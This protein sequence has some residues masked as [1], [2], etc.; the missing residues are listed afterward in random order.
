MSF[1]FVWLLAPC[2]IMYFF[3]KRFIS[4]KDY[5]QVGSGVLILVLFS[6][7]LS[8]IY[9]D[10]LVKPYMENYAGVYTRS[11]GDTVTGG[12]YDQIEY[13]TSPA[14]GNILYD[15]SATNLDELY[16]RLSV[17]N[18]LVG[19]E[20]YLFWQTGLSQGYDPHNIP[21]YE[22]PVGIVQRLFFFFFIGIHVLL[23]VTI[24]SVLKNFIPALLLL[25]VA[26]YLF[27]R[28]SKTSMFTPII[29]YPYLK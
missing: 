18:E 12:E 26:Q 2:W 16:D 13:Y 8:N 10:N 20:S 11:S 27:R 9:Y 25:I 7:P 1:S 4:K 5:W 14:L 3:F 24:V 15:A 17:D 29:I 28:K 19:K 22:E 23:E 21:L 6:A